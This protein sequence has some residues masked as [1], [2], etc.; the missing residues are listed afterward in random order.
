M[1]AA[2]IP[3]TPDADEARDWLLR[4][5]SK[6]EYEAARP[7]WFDR[8]ASAISDW[9]FSLQVPDIGGGSGLGLAVILTL[10]VI[11]LVIA[12]LIFGV[13]RLNKR[14]GYSFELFG[15]TDVRDAAQLRTAAEASAARGEFD[16]AIA[17]M[18]R[19]IAR[20]MVERTVLTTTPGTTA[21]DFAQRVAV[22]FPDF[23]PRLTAAARTFDE[24]RY[25]GK[26]GTSEGYLAVADLEKDLRMTRPQFD[27]VTV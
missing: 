1:L 13:P 17:E 21:H 22:A 20:G 18:F 24:V 14:S 25:L 4:E 26:T 5:L 15:D 16:L 11:A 10:V 7:T 3:V 2:A 12:F 6:A 23:L 27:E 8:L 9:F 19:A